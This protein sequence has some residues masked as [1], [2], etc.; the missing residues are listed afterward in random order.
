MSAPSK[1]KAALIILF[2]F[3]FII[4]ISCGQK[5]DRVEKITEDGVEVVVNHI[6]PY[7]YP[8]Y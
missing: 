1:T 3:V 6:Q 2:L 5:Q 4:F 8:L 7:Q